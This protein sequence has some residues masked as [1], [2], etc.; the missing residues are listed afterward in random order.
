MKFLYRLAF[1]FA[2]MAGFALLIQ[3]CARTDASPRT[4]DPAA[5]ALADL[6]TEP[7][8]GID[9]MPFGASKET[10]IQELGLPER[11]YE[12][13]FGNTAPTAFPLLIARLKDTCVQ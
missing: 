6:A 3:G 8:Q 10:L 9:S 11:D 2:L 12:R 1:P 5:V 7:A 4:G 13:H